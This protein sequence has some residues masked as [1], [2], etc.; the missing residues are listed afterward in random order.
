MLHRSFSNGK[1]TTPASVPQAS[2]FA[3]AMGHPFIQ[4]NGIICANL[5]IQISALMWQL[6]CQQRFA[7]HNK[8]NHCCRTTT[9]DAP[10]PMRKASRQLQTCTAQREQRNKK[11][12]LETSI[13]MPSQFERDSTAK[14]RRPHPPCKGTTFLH[15]GAAVYA[16]K[17]SYSFNSSHS[18]GLFQC[19]LATVSFTTHQESQH[20]LQKHLLLFSGLL[21][22]SPICSTRLSSVCS[23][24]L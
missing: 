10:A 13:P 18:N 24:L 19:D 14:R 12:H 7:K 9:L 11:N 21:Y 4:K 2:Q 8:E 17:L 15:N 16:K 23:S 3:P 20:M 1:A 5:N 22:S 6:Q